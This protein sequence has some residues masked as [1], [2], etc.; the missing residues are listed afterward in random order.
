MCDISARV[1][2][3]EVYVVGGYMIHE[4]LSVVSPFRIRK[5][6]DR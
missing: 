2:P 4:T 1:M 5:G 6:K 3:V